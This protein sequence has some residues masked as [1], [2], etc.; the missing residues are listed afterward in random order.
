MSQGLVL[1]WARCIQREQCS[2]YESA[3][4][5][6]PWKGRYFG[7]CGWSNQRWDDFRVRK[8]MIRKV[9]KAV[10]LTEWSAWL[11]RMSNFPTAMYRSMHNPANRAEGK[12]EIERGTYEPLGHINGIRVST[13]QAR[14]IQRVATGWCWCSNSTRRIEKLSVIIPRIRILEIEKLFF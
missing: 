10:I 1:R 2:E 6:R 4:R 9:V 8:V 3:L 7:L 13:C 11:G 12:S 5:S 14:E